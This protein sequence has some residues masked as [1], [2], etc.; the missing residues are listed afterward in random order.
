M[1]CD[2]FKRTPVRSKRNLSERFFEARTANGRRIKLNLVRFEANVFTLR[3]SF[4]HF[5][6]NNTN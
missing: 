6:P 3:S 1:L 2:G 5:I 4:C